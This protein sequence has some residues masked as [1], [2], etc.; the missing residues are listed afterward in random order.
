MREARIARAYRIPATVCAGTLLLAAV[1]AAHAVSP[2][3]LPEWYYSQGHLLEQ[4]VRSD[5]APQWSRVIGLS[6]E[7]SPKYEGGNAYETSGGPSFDLRYRDIAFASSGEGIGVNLLHSRDYRAGVALNV[8]LGRD[9]DADHHLKGLGDVGISPQAAVFAEY[10]IFPVT[11]R[12]DIRHSFGGEGGWVGDIS[13]YTPL[14]GSQK[15]FVFAG[16]SLTFANGNAQRHYFG[17]SPM[18]SFESGYPEYHA[19]MGLR[20]GS[21]GVSAGYFLTQRWLVTGMLAA[22]QLFGSAG[23]SP[24]VQEQ[25]QLI[26]TFT[27]AYRW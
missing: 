19:S 9:Q 27:A 3:P 6:V 5:A 22:E 20:S 25:G 10:L 13:A 24:L 15:Y 8:D 21:F 16:P 26:A 17:I 1:D 12:I 7:T 14:A 4:H 2:S 23:H 11:L 18:Q